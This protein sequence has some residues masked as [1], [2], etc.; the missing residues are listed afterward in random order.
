M[1]IQSVIVS[2]E[3]L[4]KTKDAIANAIRT[5][6]VTS[7]GRFSNFPNEI[8]SIQG[9]GNSAAYQRIINN[10]SKYNIVKKNKDNELVVMGG[11]KETFEVVNTNNVTIY[12][13][14]D[15]ENVKIED[16][17]YKNRIKQQSDSNARGLKLGDYDCGVINYF[18]LE[19]SISPIE[20]DNVNGNVSI[21]YTTAGAEHTV[22][23]PVQDIKAHHPSNNSNNNQ[24]VYWFVQDVFDPNIDS[25]NLR[26]ITSVEDANDTDV[27][28]YG[29]V[30]TLQ[31]YPH[32]PSI[33]DKLDTVAGYDTV[34]AILTLN[35]NGNI[36]E[37]IPVKLARNIFNDTIPLGEG[38]NG[39][40]LE[41][42]GSSLMF[43]YSNTTGKL[44]TRFIISTTGST[45]QTDSN[46]VQKIKELK[47]DINAYV[48]I[49]MHS[50]GSPITI[51]EAKEAGM[52]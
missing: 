42:D 12:S 33:F 47:K 44:S 9:G 38:S 13:L 18:R 11:V 52:I 46:I 39:A 5:K 41:F 7:L 1:D 37:T 21:K 29:R 8:K 2:F 10:I 4:N 31:T 16:G 25:K 27:S 50:D 15:I 30:N 43:H 14:Y 23:M 35:K 22:V 6:G 48:G 40:V 36:I 28:F 34:N 26:Q 45:N 3:E 51:A 20:A 49:A 19:L 32:R 24:A 17:V